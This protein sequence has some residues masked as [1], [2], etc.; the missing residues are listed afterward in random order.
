MNCTHCGKPVGDDRATLGIDVY[1]NVGCASDRITATIERNRELDPTFKL[2][3]ALFAHLNIH[4]SMVG[5]HGH[6]TK[7]DYT[8]LQDFVLKNGRGFKSSNC[9]AEYRK[10]ATP[11]Q[12]F[13]NA[14]YLAVARDFVYVEGYAISIIPTLHAWCYDQK[15]DKIIDPTWEYRPEI[16]YIGVPIKTNYVFDMAERAEQYSV[17]DAWTINWPIM[18]DPKEEWYYDLKTPAECT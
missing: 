4:C 14:F 8:C 16:E 2:A 5:T 9:S 3:P 7:R 17:L 10:H 18:S 13:K 12:C 11:R 15:T 1:C 6:R